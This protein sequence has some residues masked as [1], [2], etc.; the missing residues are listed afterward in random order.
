MDLEPLVRRASS[1]D[2]K[3]FV[4]LTRRFQQFAFGSALALVG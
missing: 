3:A 1:G 2:V 4:A